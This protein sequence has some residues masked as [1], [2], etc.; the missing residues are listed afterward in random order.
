MIRCRIC[1]S[2]DRDALVEEM[3]EALWLSYRHDDVPWAQVDHYWGIVFRQL[4]E[5]A[6]RVSGR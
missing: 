2:N 6:I 1:A 5:T 3:A 4:A